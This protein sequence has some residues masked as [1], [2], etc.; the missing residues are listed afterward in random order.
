MLIRKLTAADARALLA[1]RLSGVARSPDAFLA[2]HAEVAATPLSRVESELE[3]PDIHCLGAFDGHDLLGVVRY[4]RAARLSRRH[5]AQ[6]RGVCAE[7]AR[8]RGVG[9]RLL[10][11]LIEDARRCGIESLV[12][13]VLADNAPARGLYEAAGFQPYG[14]EPRA[15]RKDGRYVDQVLYRLELADA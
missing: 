11:R 7:A 8:G 3:D 13:D 15:V 9:A 4:V 1:C 5:V 14:L 10:S 2:S 6:V 12:L